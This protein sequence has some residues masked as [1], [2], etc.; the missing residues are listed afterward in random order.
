MYIP[1]KNAKNSAKEKKI[2]VLERYVIAS[3]LSDLTET[4]AIGERPY[5]WL[6]GVFPY[7]KKDK[8]F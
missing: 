7:R 3:Y 4:S 6:L 8:K 2:D 5:I 1:K